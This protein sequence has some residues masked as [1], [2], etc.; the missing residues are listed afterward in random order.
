MN[1]VKGVAELPPPKKKE[2]NY[3]VI[4]YYT[5]WLLGL[6]RRHTPFTIGTDFFRSSVSSLEMN[7]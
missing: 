7:K 6:V 3:P 2:K 5:Q 1:E 4:S